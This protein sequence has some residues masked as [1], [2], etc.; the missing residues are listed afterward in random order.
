MT[1][2]NGVTMY[3]MMLMTLVAVMTLGACG[4]DEPTEVNAA[5]TTALRAPPDDGEPLVAR[6][7]E[8]QRVAVVEYVYVTTLNYAAAVEQ[9]KVDEVERQR[10]VAML[11]ANEERDRTDANDR[12]ESRALEGDRCGGALPPCWVLQRESRGD[13]GAVNPTGCSGRTCGGAWQFDPR[14]W[15]SYGGYARAEDAPPDVQDAK[16]VELW[17][18]GD[19]CSHWNACG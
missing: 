9:A 8:A 15:D 13:Y 11:A 4:T 17:A 19:G 3:R 16:A 12:A 10:V 18:G 7:E 1:I 2:M 6:A 14:T 5:T